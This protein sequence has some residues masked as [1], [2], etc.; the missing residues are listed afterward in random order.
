MDINDQ[1][2]KI[3][4]KFKNKENEKKKKKFLE[5]EDSFDLSPRMNK[6]LRS[7]SHLNNMMIKSEKCYKEDNIKNF[8]ID[9]LDGKMKIVENDSLDGVCKLYY[10]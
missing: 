6:P 1:N 8:L 7:S 3:S 10:N 5:E 4:S 9:V 2:L